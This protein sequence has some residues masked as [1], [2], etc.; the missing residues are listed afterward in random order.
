MSASGNTGNRISEVKDLNFLKS[1]KEGGKKD[2]QEVLDT[3]EN[4]VTMTWDE[5]ADICEIVSGSKLPDID[6]P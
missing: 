6:E 4:H 5:G 2:Y 1:P 3:I